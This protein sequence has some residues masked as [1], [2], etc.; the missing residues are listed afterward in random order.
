MYIYIYIYTYLAPARPAIKEKPSQG[1]KQH[2]NPFSH[3][4]KYSVVYTSCDF[5]VGSELS[6]GKE[7]AQSANQV[8]DLCTLYV[9]G[10]SLNQGLLLM[11][12]IFTKLREAPTSHQVLSCANLLSSSRCTTVD[13]PLGFPP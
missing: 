6:S 7:H 2:Q 5:P 1:C 9:V 13:V 10:I 4:V 8:K 11:G 3:Y 12:R